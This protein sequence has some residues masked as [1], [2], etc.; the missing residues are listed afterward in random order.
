MS[1]HDQAIYHNNFI[2]DILVRRQ[3]TPLPLEVAGRLIIR[4][5]LYIRWGSACQ[6]QAVSDPKRQFRPVIEL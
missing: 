4:L 5:L 2:K 1:V 3:E 6:D